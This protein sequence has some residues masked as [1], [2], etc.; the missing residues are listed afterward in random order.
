MEAEVGSETLLLQF[1]IEDEGFR[2]IYISKQVVHFIV[3]VQYR[4]VHSTLY[5]IIITE[6]H[7]LSLLVV[8]LSETER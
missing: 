6:G 3:I 4:G 7:S 5:L 2:I 8:V 1:S